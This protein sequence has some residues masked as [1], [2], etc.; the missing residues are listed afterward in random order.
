[1]IDVSKTDLT[2]VY[3]LSKR[4]L[5]Y[6]KKN[7]EDMKINASGQL[8]RTAD[9]DVEFSDYHLAVYFIIESY[10]TYVERGRNKSTGKW[11]SWTSKVTDI[12]QWLR[13][14]IA[15]GS[16]I[17]TSGHT[18]PRTDKEIKSV[19]Y[20]IAR[21]ITRVGFYGRTHYGKHPLEEAI[22]QAEA[23]GI[24]DEIIDCVVDGFAG[25]V[26]IEIEKL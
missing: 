7:L 22:K 15:R 3:N 14:K 26:D 8:S 2:K 11:G 12:E 18:I 19:S 5:D 20:L 23:A 6:Y 9:F 16:F 21:K 25:A 10:Y 4:I 13:L 17:P 24:I 1:M